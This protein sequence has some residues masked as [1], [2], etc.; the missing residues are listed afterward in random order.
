MT[1]RPWFWPLVGVAVYVAGV[2][3]ELLGRVSEAWLD[4]GKGVQ[5][6]IVLVALA[7]ALWMV[8]GVLRRRNAA[9]HAAAHAAAPERS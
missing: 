5:I 2:N 4:L 3:D 6:V 8:A 7:L 1:R 9:Y